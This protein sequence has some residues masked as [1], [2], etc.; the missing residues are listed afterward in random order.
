AASHAA[1]WNVK[2]SPGGIRD[3]EFLT[4]CLQRLYGGSDA[5]LR[6][7]STLVALQRLHDKGHLSGRD[8]F[9]LGAA[10]QFLRRVEHRLQLRDGLQ[11]HT[12]PQPRA[13]PK[14]ATRAGVCCTFSARLCST[15]P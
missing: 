15:P 3:I 8:F 14:M 5:W 9:R 13:A 2:L 4:Q 10:Y 6:S 12:L 1:E 7:N 11:R